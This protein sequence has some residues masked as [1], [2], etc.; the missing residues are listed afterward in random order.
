[1]LADELRSA[2]RDIDLCP[3]SEVRGLGKYDAVIVGGALYANRWH[4]D[5]RRFVQQNIEQLRRVPVWFFS[6]GPLD[7]SAEE[8]S[9][10]PTR[11]V[12]A[13]LERVGAHGHET[14]GGRLSADARGF[15]AGAMAKEHAGDWRNPE[16]IR[17]WAAALAN[18]LPGAKPGRAIDHPAHS[19]WRVVSHGV[20]G[21]AACGVIM[22]GLLATTTVGVALLVHA[23]TAPLVFFL[24]GMHYFARLGSREPLAVALSFTGIVV[25]L[26]A[27]VIGGLIQGSFAMFSSFSGTWLPFALIFLATY[28][29]GLTVS[30]LPLPTKAKMAPLPLRSSERATHS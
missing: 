12:Q 5:A 13:L 22:G 16:H 3:A 11:Q 17:R 24:V 7:A 18:E 28:L 14:F 27:F 19:P 30:I 15:P 1:M 21:W 8:R 20:V 23:I 6:S 25:L 29:A 4:R 9:I 10:P 26:D 2:D